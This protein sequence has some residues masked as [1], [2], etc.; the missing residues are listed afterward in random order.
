M[1]KEAVKKSFFDLG[2]SASQCEVM[3]RIIGGHGLIALSGITGSGKSLIA[4]AV[5]NELM[6][7]N[8]EKKIAFI[9]DGAEM[10]KNIKAAMRSDPDVIVVDEV[11]DAV[12]L[13]LVTKVAQ[14]GCLC[15]FTIFGESIFDCESRL[16]SS[17]VGFD[18]GVLSAIVHQRILEDNNES[19]PK[20]KFVTEIIEMHRN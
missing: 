15:V 13:D 1:N 7:R 11:R 10:H 8:P 2:F 18:S 4:L 14:S 12:G 20:F 19:I 6:T 17:G 5:V 9:K 16:N 3:N